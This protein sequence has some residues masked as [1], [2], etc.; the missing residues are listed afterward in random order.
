MI[1]ECMDGN[2]DMIIT[3]NLPFDRWNEIFKDQVLTTAIIDRLAYKSHII[4]LSGVSYRAQETLKW[5]NSK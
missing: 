5:I 3:T 2:I 4:D 1:A